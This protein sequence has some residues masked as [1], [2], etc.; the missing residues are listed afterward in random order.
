MPLFI[1]DQLYVMLY[2]TNEACYPG[3]HPELPAVPDL[4]QIADLLITTCSCFTHYTVF[5]SALWCAFIGGVIDV[6]WREGKGRSLSCSI[7]KQLQHNHRPP[8]PVH[9]Q[10]QCRNNSDCDWV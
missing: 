10:Q 6:N 8:S 2:R 3:C 4:A 5:L 9:P 1:T 7:E